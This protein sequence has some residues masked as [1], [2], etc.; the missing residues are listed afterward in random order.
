MSS[1][2]AY[3]K[4]YSNNAMYYVLAYVSEYSKKYN[5]FRLGIKKWV[6]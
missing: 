6:Q 1:V 5:V 3:V 4:K 2:L